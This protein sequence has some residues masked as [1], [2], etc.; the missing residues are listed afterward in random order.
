MANVDIGVPQL[1]Q[2]FRN[3]QYNNAFTPQEDTMLQNIRKTAKIHNKLLNM[4]DEGYQKFA[5]LDNDVQEM[6]RAFYGEETEYMIEPQSG[7]GGAFNTLK[8]VVGTV[9][10]SPF[11]ALFKG[12][13]EYSDVL[14]GVQNQVLQVLRLRE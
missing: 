7:F 6:L 10:T 11:K 14:N 4:G 8:N 12:L 3:L 13:E 9:I 2:T 5:K 1:D